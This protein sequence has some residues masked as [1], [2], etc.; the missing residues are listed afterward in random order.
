MGE[1]PCLGMRGV[2][3][4]DSAGGC[5]LEAEAQWPLRRVQW[6]LHVGGGRR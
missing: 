4:P 1:G 2:A 6:V 5:D 3:D